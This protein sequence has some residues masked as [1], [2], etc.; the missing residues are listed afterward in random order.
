MSSIKSYI[1]TLYKRVVSWF[2]EILKV[3]RN[4]LAG[5]LAAFDK[6][7][8]KLDKFLD[9]AHADL[10]NLAV[11]RE[12]VQREIEAKNTEIDRAY[13]ISHRLNELTK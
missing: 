9:E 2:R 11:I 6:A 10:K 5:A 1:L 4:D 13:R 3:F 12:T 7:A 8:A